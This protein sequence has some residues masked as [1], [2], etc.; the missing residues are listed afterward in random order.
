MNTIVG[1][2]GKE[3]EIISWHLF[4]IGSCFVLSDNYYN[5][6][7]NHSSSL[8]QIYTSQ[9]DNDNICKSLKLLFNDDNIHLSLYM[10]R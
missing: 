7:C 6:C 10:T 3:N 9:I 8:H 2:Y 5:M 1:L 4:C